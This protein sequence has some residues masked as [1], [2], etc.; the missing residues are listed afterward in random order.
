MMC[1]NFIYRKLISATIHFYREMY[2]LIFRLKMRLMCVNI[3]IG[4]DVSIGRMVLVQATDGGEIVIGDGVTIQDFCLL[5]ARN[6]RLEIGDQTFLGVGSQLVAI[7]SIQVGQDCL[8]SA[9]SIIRDANH[10]MERGVPMSKQ[11]HNSAPIIIGNDVWLGAHAVV[12]AGSTIGNGAVIGA[13]A[14]VTRNV[15]E[16]AIVVGVPAKII[17]FR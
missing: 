9:Y 1:C 5:C 3:I 6:G 17:K 4:K 13:N 12:T 15:P 11:S 16:Y 2:S 7:E 8:I 14:V 10:G